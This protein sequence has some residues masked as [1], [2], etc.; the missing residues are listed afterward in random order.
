M[1]VM[2]NPAP[3]GS[4]RRVCRSTT[5]EVALAPNSIGTAPLMTRTLPISPAGSAPRSTRPSHG[6]LSGAPSRKT[7]VCR[8]SAPRTRAIVS[9]RELV[10]TETPARP[11]SASATLVAWRMSSSAAAIWTVGGCTR[12]SA[13]GAVTTMSRSGAG[14]V[15]TIGLSLIAGLRGVSAAMWIGDTI[16]VMAMINGC[17]GV[18]SR[19]Y[20]QPD[21]TDTVSAVDPALR[22]APAPGSISRV[23]E[24]RRNN[25]G[26]SS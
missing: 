17:I 1:P 26:Q 7:A 21:A 3:P 5:P 8:S 25:S 4:A 22:Y 2:P 20:E 11:P 16:A 23:V 12:C 6:T 14:A 24:R 10:L 19:R 13:S 15:S 9:P 18:P